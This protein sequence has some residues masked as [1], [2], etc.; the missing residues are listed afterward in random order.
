MVAVEDWITAVMTRPSRKAFS[1]VPVTFS[2]T[3]FS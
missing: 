1:G 3:R 2:M